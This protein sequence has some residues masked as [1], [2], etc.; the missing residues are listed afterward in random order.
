MM[1]LRKKVLAVFTATVLVLSMMVGTALAST[2]ELPYSYGNEADVQTNNDVWVVLYG[3]TAAPELTGDE[4]VRDSVKSVEVTISGD[5]SFTPEIIINSED[6]WDAE[7]FSSQTVDGSTTVSKDFDGTGQG[8]VEVIVNLM[9]KSEGSLEIT[10]IDFKDAS[11]NVVVST[12]GT[13]APAAPTEET[14]AADDAP[15]TDDAPAEESPKTGVVS[16]ALFLGLGAI[17]SASAAVVLKK[18]ED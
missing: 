1:K 8:Y 16:S 15:A 10:R 4:A 11:G 2:H 13:D 17:V 18:K 7:T 14:P 3:G 9:G 12:G 5:A 6:G